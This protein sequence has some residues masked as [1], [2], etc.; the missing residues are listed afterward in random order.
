MVGAASDWPP[1]PHGYPKALVFM[2]WVYVFCCFPIVPSTLPAWSWALTPLPNF[3]RLPS[4]SRYVKLLI[5][6]LQSPPHH[7]IPGAPAPCALSFFQSISL[8][9]VFGFFYFG[10]A[11]DCVK[12]SVLLVVFQKGPGSI[13][14]ESESHGQ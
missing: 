12:Y 7:G 11:Y 5:A 9:L 8:N 13:F 2:L 10:V 6:G 4:L 1:G 14:G 3:C